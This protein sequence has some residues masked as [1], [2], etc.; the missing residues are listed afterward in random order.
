[1]MNP[2]VLFWLY[3]TSASGKTYGPIPLQLYGTVS[4]F[5]DYFKPLEPLEPQHLS[6][7]L[8]AFFMV[9]F[10]LALLSI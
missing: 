2:E 6:Q 7:S 3:E 5:W 9:F 1:M 4:V 8:N 10:I